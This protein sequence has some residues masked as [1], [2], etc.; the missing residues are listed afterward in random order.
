MT[1]LDSTLKNWDITLLT[2]VCLVKAMVF[3][4]VMVWMWELDY[5]KSWLLNIWCFSTVVLEKT[6]ESPLDCKKIQ[7]VHPKGDQSWIFIGRTDAEAPILWPADAKSQLIRKDPDARPWLRARGEG[8]DRGWDGWMASPTQC[9]WVWA[10]SGSWWWTGRSMGSQRVRHDWATELNWQNFMQTTEF[11]MM[12]TTRWKGRWEDVWKKPGVT[13]QASA[14]SCF[15]WWGSGTQVLIMSFVFHYP[16]IR[17]DVQFISQELWAPGLC[18]SVVWP[19]LWMYSIARWRL[20]L[21]C[22][23]PCLG[24]QTEVTREDKNHPISAAF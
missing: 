11:R 14:V 3:P 20:Q 15:L 1:N 13:F 12:F 4:V 17:F 5:K 16:H 9:T 22:S 2:K 8:D 19:P 21:L 18:Q 6:L 23:P 10:S 24:C 7:L